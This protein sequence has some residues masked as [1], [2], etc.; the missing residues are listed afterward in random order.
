[1]FLSPNHKVSTFVPNLL[2]DPRMYKLECRLA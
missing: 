2:V 1:M